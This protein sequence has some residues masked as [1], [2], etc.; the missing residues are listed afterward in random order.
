[1]FLHFLVDQQYFRRPGVI[2]NSSK[3]KTF[4]ATNHAAAQS[5]S[6][7]PSHQSGLS[8]LTC[9][10]SDSELTLKEKLGN[11]SFGVVM[12]GEWKAPSGKKVNN[13]PSPIQSRD[14]R[15]WKSRVLD[16]T[17]FFFCRNHI[18]EL[19]FSSYHYGNIIMFSNVQ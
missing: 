10:I 18:S 9:L 6:S 8:D 5:M 13:S 11:G 4:T 7:S 2:E 16:F 14:Y 15:E 12:K 3:T 17:S 1:M 19:E